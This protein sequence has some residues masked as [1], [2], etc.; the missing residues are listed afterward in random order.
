MTS[1]PRPS[2]GFRD[3]A[4]FHVRRL[5]LN[6]VM[7]IGSQVLP[8][9]AGAI[10]IPVIYRNIGRADFGVFTIGLSALGLFALLDLGLGRAAVRFQA[11]AFAD[12]QPTKAASVVVHSALL[13]GGFSLTLCLIL[14]ALA[15]LIAAH[16]IQSQREPNDTL[17]QCLYILAAALPF[18]G[19]TSVFRSVLEAREDFVSIGIIQ[20]ILGILTYVVPLALSF[21]TTDVRV[22]IAGAVA[23]RILAFAAFMVAARV[24]WR[25]KF[26]WRSVNLRGE[27]EFRDYSLWTV[28]SNLIGTAIV[29][30]DRALLVRLFGLA[31]IPF[32]NVPLEMLGRMMIIVNSA[33]TVVFPALSRFAGNRVVMEGVYVSLVTLLSVAMGIAMLGLS[34]LTPAGLNLWLGAD[35]RDHSSLLV[36]ILLVGLAF[37]CLNVMSLAALNARGFARP[38]TMMHLTETPLYFIALYL[39]GRRFG[40]TGVALVWSARLM[41]EYAC[42]TGFQMYVVARDGV[43]R[44]SVG[45]TLAACNIIPLGLVAFGGG[46]AAILVSVA[47]AIV[48]VTWALFEL[49]AVQKLSTLQALPPAGS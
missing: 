47:A 23:C 4:L 35:F 36:R 15:P 41:V 25:G 1:P 27:Q 12:G 13:L 43:R 28:V 39:C 26:P 3:R 6:V 45:A 17:R 42:F 2:N 18:A 20:S 21:W 40:L 46:T 34:F 24:A 44:Q 19:L 49:R 11:R 48:S 9:L 29:Y 5:S 38:I 37:Q 32:Y 33:A 16:W 30:G 8:L 22:I 10:A 31:E 14:F 7:Q